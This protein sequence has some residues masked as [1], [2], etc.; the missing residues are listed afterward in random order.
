MRLDPLS[1]PIQAFLG[2][3]LVWARR[4]DQAL[5]Q[6]KQVERLNPNFPIV[7]ERLAHLYTYM[8][9]YGAAISSETRARLLAGEDP[10]VVMAKEEALRN[11][12]A[13]RGPAG[14]WQTL[15]DMSQSQDNPP[16]AYNTTYGLAI[17]FARLGDRDQS[18][19][20]LQKAYE[21][22]QLALT[23]VGVEP[24]LD[25]LR[26]DQR[27]VELLRRVGLSR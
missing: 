16:E 27:F 7:Q 12:L 9:D 1:L 20:Q 23:E 19:K 15:L 10:Q 11:A 24:A 26:S 14:Y 25:G 5:T 21:E 17:V 13:Q 18:L 2:R 22:R 6:L 3:T 8:G 4:Y